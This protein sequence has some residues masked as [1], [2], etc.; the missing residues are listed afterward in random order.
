MKIVRVGKEVKFLL[1]SEEDIKCLKSDAI[2]KLR[3]MYSDA[4]NEYVD[5]S[6]SD[7][8]SII[9]EALSQ[10]GFDI[11]VEYDLGYH[12]GEGARIRGKW[13]SVDMSPEEAKTLLENYG[14]N[15]ELIN[16]IA[17]LLE[18]TKGHSVYAESIVNDFGIHY[19]HS[20]TVEWE[21][22]Y[23]AED[24]DDDESLLR[25]VET[26]LEGVTAAV[27]TQ[28]ENL[29]RELENDEEFIMFIIGNQ[30]EIDEEFIKEECFKKIIV[31]AEVIKR[32]EQKFIKYVLDE[33][34]LKDFELKIEK[35]EVECDDFDVI[36]E[37]ESETIDC[38]L[39]FKDLRVE[40]KET[41]KIMERIIER[42]ENE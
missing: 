30:I 33:Q 32:I 8:A 36:E 40:D 41:K 34:E 31:P 18:T 27:E 2:D 24:S 1:E 23:Y 13:Y 22:E 39:N 29:F 9:Q 16:N 15:D 12:Q 3:E 21:A 38:E 6:I 17:E 28:L 19:C 35:G 11:V 25:D 14:M 20:A 4:Y 26:L 5:M 42:S 37:V 10:V 7:E